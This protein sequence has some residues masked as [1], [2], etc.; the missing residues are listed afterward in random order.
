MPAIVGLLRSEVNETLAAT[1]LVAGLVEQRF[2]LEP[3]GTV[4]SQGQPA[5][6]LLEFGTPLAFSVARDRITWAAPLGVLFLAVV[7]L[8]VRR[9]HGSTK[10]PAN[11][12]VTDVEPEAEPDPRRQG[13]PRD[14]RPA[15]KL[16]VRLK[17]TVDGGTQRLEVEGDLTN[18]GRLITDER[19]QP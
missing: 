1:G 8:V 14:A 18:L 11:R 12:A 5:G 16:A 13:N 6:G 9:R 10:K 15:T 4:L 19:R 7:G 17:P 2:S 3:G